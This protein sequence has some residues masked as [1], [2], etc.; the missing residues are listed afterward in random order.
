M[1]DLECTAHEDYRVNVQDILT[2]RNWTQ[3]RLA[4][5]MG[6]T[7]SYI[8]QLLSGHRVPGLGVIENTADA[9]GVP[10]TRLIRSSS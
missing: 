5:E 9:L 2:R 8:H 6:C 7:P 4:E 1:A 3:K 10:I